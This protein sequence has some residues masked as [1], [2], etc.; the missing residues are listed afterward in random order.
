MTKKFLEVLKPLIKD[1]GLSKEEIESLANL[2]SKNLTETSTD[3]EIDNLAKSV[4]PIAE[5]M[6]K[7]ASRQVTAI[8]EGFKDF[9]SPQDVEKLLAEAK[10][11]E[12]EKKSE[13]GL[14]LEQVQN[15]IAEGISSKTKELNDK[16]AEYEAREKSTQLRAQLF[17]H[18]K[19]KDIPDFF[20]SRYSLDK[21]E[22]LE[23]IASQ[24]E[25]DYATMKQQLVQQEGFVEK[26]KAGGI[27][28]TD[29]LIARMHK[30]A[31]EGS[32]NKKS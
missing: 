15:L 29:D 13:E 32:A 5:I 28:E 14:T 31:E 16:I 2:Y 7:S 24:I 18:S 21:A 30:M 25:T 11:K 23:T 26:P 9:K 12:P 4:I 1:K 10:N 8:R 19:V 20:R 27:G 3:E 17:A 6:Q 22:D